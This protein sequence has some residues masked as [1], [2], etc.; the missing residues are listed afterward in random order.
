MELEIRFKGKGIKHLS[1]NTLDKTFQRIYQKVVRDKVFFESIIPSEYKPL[2]QLLE[3]TTPFVRLYSG[4]KHYFEKTELELLANILPWY[5]HRLVHL[6]WVFAY[7]R[8]AW[9]GRFY[10]HGTGGIVSWTRRA[11]GYILNGSLAIER[12]SLNVDEM[13]KLLTLFKSLIIVTVEAGIGVAA[14][15]EYAREESRHY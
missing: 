4:D 2:S 11:L 12:E 5:T 6:P 3:E 13:K 8:T 7:R 14:G 9:G 1:L 15:E 10:V